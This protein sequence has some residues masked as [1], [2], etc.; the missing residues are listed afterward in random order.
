MYKR[1]S[2][3]RR[4]R[5]ASTFFRRFRVRLVQR[6]P[7]CAHRTNDTPFKEIIEG[8]ITCVSVDFHEMGR[9]AAA[10]ILSPEKICELMPTR[11]ISR[12]SL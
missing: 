9:K 4:L 10:Q 7:A 6:I 3:T 8:G 1:W 5:Y 2:G 12:A 11:L